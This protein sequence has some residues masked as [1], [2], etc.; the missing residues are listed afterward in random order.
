MD[1]REPGAVERDR[2]GRRKVVIFVVALLRD[3]D[4]AT[5]NPQP[6]AGRVL[7]PEHLAASENQNRA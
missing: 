3:P 4:R 5:L 7:E 2:P 1:Q 6:G